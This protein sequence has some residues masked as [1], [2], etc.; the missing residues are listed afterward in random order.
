MQSQEAPA[1]P[2]YDSVSL[3]SL[4]PKA[5]ESTNPNYGASLKGCT[6]RYFAALV[7]PTL[8]IKVDCWH[9]HDV[10]QAAVGFDEMPLL[11]IAFGCR[12]L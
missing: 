3:C 9:H 10:S 1:A 12:Y 7:E 2:A 4:L 8:S 11:Q 5:A 6:A